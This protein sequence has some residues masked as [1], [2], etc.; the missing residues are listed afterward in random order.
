MENI[1][2]RW[3]L[4]FLTK[5]LSL[6]PTCTRTRIEK[7]SIKDG[8]QHPFAQETAV[9]KWTAPIAMEVSK[10][11]YSKYLEAFKRHLSMVLLS[12]LWVVALLKRGVGPHDHWRSFYP[13]PVCDDIQFVWVPLKALTNGQQL[14]NKS[15][16]QQ[17]VSCRSF[18]TVELDLIQLLIFTRGVITPNFR[19]LQLN[20]GYRKCTNH[21][22]S[23]GREG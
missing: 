10:I 13:P 14:W 11:L 16:W 17:W 2:S 19:P 3:K 4:F 1:I 22:D 18:K 12:Q 15:Q 23:E 8:I 7:L 6:F 5:L 21:C 20:E 9:W